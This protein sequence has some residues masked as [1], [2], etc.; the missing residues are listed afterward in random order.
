MTVKEVADYLRVNQRTV[1]RLAVE[2]KLPGFKVGA[3]WR[4]KRADIDGWIAAQSS[5]GN[6]GTAT[7]VEGEDKNA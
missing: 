2:Q 5:A 1:Y 6:A 4:F 3:T 7:W